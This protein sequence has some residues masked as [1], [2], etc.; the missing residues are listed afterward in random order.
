MKRIFVFVIA[1]CIL[2]ASCS[3]QENLG[4]I[5]DQVLKVKGYSSFAEITV[6]GN[7]GVSKYKVK[8]YYLEPGRLK[9]ETLEPDFLKG[10]II[11]KDGDKWKIYHPLIN[12]TLEVSQLGNSDLLILMGIIQKNIFAAANSKLGSVVENGRRFMTVTGTIPGSNRF[13][14]SAVLF[15]DEAKKIPAGMDILDDKGN[16][17]MEIRYTDFI[18]KENFEAATFD[19]K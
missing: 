10:K 3:K 2:I 8:Q 6:I 14:S 11:L 16:K 12:Q 18:Y 9:I 17:T 5:R 13:R 15:I 1:A 7:K 4:N 19:L